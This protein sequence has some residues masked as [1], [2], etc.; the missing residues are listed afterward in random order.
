MGSLRVVHVVRS[1]GVPRL[2]ETAPP[3]APYS[4]PMPKVLWGS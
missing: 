2:E 3:L 1:A 4:R